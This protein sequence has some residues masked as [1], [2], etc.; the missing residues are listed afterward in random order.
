VAFPI[1]IALAK[2]IRRQP[3]FMVLAATFAATTVMLT[4]F[5]GLHRLNYY[6]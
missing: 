1:V 2:V 5:Y 3:A 6:P 4:V